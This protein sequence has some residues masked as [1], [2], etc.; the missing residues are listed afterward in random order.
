MEV[1]VQPCSP[2]LMP[3]WGQS[4][5][6]PRTEQHRARKLSLAGPSEPG[7]DPLLG[8]TTHPGKHKKPPWERVT[9]FGFAFSLLS[10]SLEPPA[11]NPFP[12]RSE[13]GL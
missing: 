11:E 4:N 5:P 1:K 8:Q 12:S 2:D 9:S 7:E 6:E 3:C 13:D 10:P